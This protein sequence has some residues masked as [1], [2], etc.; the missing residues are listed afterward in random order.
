MKDWHK[1]D[2]WNVASG[3]DNRLLRKTTGQGG[4]ATDAGPGQPSAEPQPVATK[5]NAARM[6]FH[7]QS[8]NCYV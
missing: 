5:S 6:T 3:N 7:G 2:R 8:G 4:A 1:P